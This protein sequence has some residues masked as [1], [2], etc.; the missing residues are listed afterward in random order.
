MKI[1]PPKPATL[2]KYGLTESQWYA[3]LREQD[4]KC[5]ICE[6]EFTEKLRPVCDH[7]HSK[8]YNKVRGKRPKLTQEQRYKTL[9][10]LLC[11]KCNHSLLPTWMTTMRA[12]NVYDYLLAFDERYNG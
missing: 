7:Y 6:R 4:Y 9:R 5:P 3:I 11:A 1:R 8:I 10:G 12:W 2:R